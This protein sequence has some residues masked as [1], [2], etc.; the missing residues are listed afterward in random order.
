M[1]ELLLNKFK[2]LTLRTAAE[3]YSEPDINGLWFT[4][5]E[6]YLC[7]DGLPIFDDWVHYDTDGLHPELNKILEKN[8]WYA[9]PYDRATL[10]I[11]PL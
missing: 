1:K 6:E 9:E 4:N 5:G 10:L 3:F 7:A 11:Y 8:N 2:G